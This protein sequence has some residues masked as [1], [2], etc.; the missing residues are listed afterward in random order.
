MATHKEGDGSSVCRFR[1]LF[2]FGYFACWKKVRQTS[3][4]VEQAAR[5]CA[6]EK[7]RAGCAQVLS[8]DCR[9][10]HDLLACCRGF[11][12]NDFD[13]SHDWSPPARGLSGSH[14]LRKVESSVGVGRWRF[15][16]YLFCCRRCF[17]AIFDNVLLWFLSR[18]Q[19]K[20][21][22][23]NRDCPTIYGVEICNK[24]SKAYQCLRNVSEYFFAVFTLA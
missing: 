18:I 19:D 22:L 1:R 16:K 4:L 13:F 6:I 12:R 10:V 17:L 21:V 20:C 8:R 11:L 9:G 3:G 7:L 15:G 14:E 24:G 5:Q 2:G 23:M